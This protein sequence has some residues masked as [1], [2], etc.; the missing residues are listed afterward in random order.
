MK[1]VYPA[2][3]TY[4]PGIIIGLVILII[5]FVNLSA[6]AKHGYGAIFGG[7][8]LTSIGVLMLIIRPH[9]EIV[10]DKNNDSDTERRLH[11]LTNLMRKGLI[12]SFE[13][14]KKRE[15]ILKRI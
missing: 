11:E 10:E 2:T 15:E 8:A 1:K 9:T 6:G 14:Q 7:L 3:W 5:G 4:Y 12:T 13:Y